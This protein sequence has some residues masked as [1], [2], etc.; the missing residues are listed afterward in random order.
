[1]GYN[2]S[3]N[4]V[5]V[6]GYLTK[7]PFYT[8]TKKGVNTLR[9]TV[10]TGRDMM[11]GTD[12]HNIAVY[13]K[14]AESLAKF[15]KK[16]MEVNVFGW[17]YV[18]NYLDKQTD[19]WNNS[20]IINAQEVKVISSKKKESEEEKFDMP[21]NEISYDEVPQGEDSGLIGMEDLPFF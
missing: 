4:R 9:F 10:I 5:E 11:E 7:D 6:Q 8:Q 15:L 14:R 13:G 16:G 12:A 21:P 20:Y 19:H 17:L 2:K 18:K 3:I 1:M